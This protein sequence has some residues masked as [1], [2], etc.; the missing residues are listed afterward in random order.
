MLNDVVRYWR[1]MA[2]DY[3]AK[4]RERDDQGWA[5]RRLKLRTSR[6][7]IFAAGLV[8][9][10][11]Y[12]VRVVGEDALRTE[13]NR[14]ALLE[15]LVL[16]VGRTPL[17]TLAYVALEHPDLASPAGAVLDAYDRFLGL[18]D[19]EGGRKALEALSR[20]DAGTSEELVHAEAIGDEF[21][22]AIEAFFF[23]SVY[24]LAIR[25]YGVF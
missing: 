14:A 4:R 22:S 3:S 7:L 23:G 2:V 18:L 19:D 9:C 20:D 13:P 12:H 16:H 6:K 5:L 15:N 21:G 10:L 25:K 11:D 1:T 8:M 17:E 24:K